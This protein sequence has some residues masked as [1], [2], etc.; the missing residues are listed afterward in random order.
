MKNQNPVAPWLFLLPAFL[1]F[2][3]YV[4][5]PIFQS[6]FLS[7]YEWDGIGEKEF[8]GWE[9]YIE[10]FYDPQFIVSIKNNVL[11]L[12]FLMLAPVF[13]LSLALFLNQK[14]FGIRLIKSLY[15]FPFVISLVIVGVI[16]SW[17]YD[18]HLG[19]LN[20]LLEFMGIKGPAILADENLVT[21]GIIFAALWPQTA[22]CMILY[23][24]GLTAI[25]SEQVEAARIDGAKGWYMLWYVIIPQLRPATFIAIVVTVIGALRSFD[26]VA[27]MTAGGP[28]N[29]SSVLAY[30]MYEQS[31]FS[32]RVGYGAAIATVLFFVTLVYISYFLWRMIRQ[33]IR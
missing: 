4:I 27:I 20:K 8:I 13:G 18:P 24:T 33:E 16:F 32:Y 23:L 25:S 22:Y 17:F 1:L 6:I 3:V 29:S 5:Y 31:V 21:Y 9:N 26:L 15:F 14:T 19:L 30:F 2:G 10:L 11:W 28:Y 7:F 12:L